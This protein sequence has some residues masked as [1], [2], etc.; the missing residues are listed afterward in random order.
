MYHQ[1][2]IWEV[3]KWKAAFQTRY[4]YLKYQ[5]IPFGLS[6][7]SDSFQGYINKIL[8]K[9]LNIFVM[10]YLD[11]ILIYTKDPNQVYVEVIY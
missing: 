6:N 3:D 8:A 9:K 1:M 2:Q 5:V 7:A 4:G 10:M 11:N